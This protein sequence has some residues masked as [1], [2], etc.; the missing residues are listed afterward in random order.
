MM[1]YDIYVHAAIPI[2]IY[3]MISW[4]MHGQMVLFQTSKYPWHYVQ[5]KFE[6]FE[7]ETTIDGGGGGGGGGEGGGGRGGGGG[8]KRGGGGEKQLCKL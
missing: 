6:P 1:I 2:P 5:A 4:Y 3:M 8:G 7:T